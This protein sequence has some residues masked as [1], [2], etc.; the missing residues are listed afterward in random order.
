MKLLALSQYKYTLVTLLLLTGISLIFTGTAFSYIEKWS[1]FDESLGHGFL[2]FAI[3]IVEIFRLSNNYIPKVEKKYHSLLLVI[4]FLAF[5]HEVSAFWGILIFQQLCFYFLWLV[6]I[7]YVL[8]L[9][10]LKHISFPLA[11]FLFAVP[12][13]EFSNT[14]FVNLTTQAVT[15]FLA[16]SDLTVYIHQNFI[17]TPYGVIEVAEGCSGIRYF[18]IGFALAVYATHGENLSWRLK[19]SVVLTGIALGILTNWI[20]VLGLIYIGYW[21]EMTSPLMNEHDTY[22]F[23]LFF[24]VISGVILLINWLRKHYSLPTSKPDEIVT[25]NSSH[26]TLLKNI[27]LKFVIA[28]TILLLTASIISANLT[29]SLSNKKV[30]KTT[31]STPSSKVLIDFGQFTEITSDYIHQN[32]KCTLTSRSYDLIEPGKNVLPYNEIINKKNFFQQDFNKEMINYLGHEI[33]VNNFVLNSIENKKRSSLFYWYEY[34]EYHFTN[35]Y[36]AKL[37]EITYLVQKNH[38][39]KLNAIWCQN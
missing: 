29:S 4:I 15:A 26:D 13:W 34:D 33:K 5:S 9:N 16:F 27:T 28:L 23:I 38:K 8:G 30:D 10:Y 25:S 36:L 31:W 2:I 19:L 22:G 37:F 17:E 35:K 39:M 11:F 32:S 7:G 21:S 18:E 3:V 1:K 12:F 24:F 6:V 14:F 20:R